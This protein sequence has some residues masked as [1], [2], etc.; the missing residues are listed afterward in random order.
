M[1]HS[2]E[3]PVNLH[4]ISYA[5]RAFAARIPILNSM[6]KQLPGI[7]YKIYTESDIPQD[8]IDKLGPD[9]WGATKGAGYMCWKPWIINDY[10]CQMPDGHNLI[11]IDAGCTSNLVK[12][13]ARRKLNEYLAQVNNPAKCGML[14]YFLPK[15]KECNYTNQYFWDYMAARYSSAS[16]RYPNIATSDYYQTPQIMS[17]VMFMRKCQW[18][19][20]LF[21]EAIQIILD[22][23]E[24][25]SEKHT[26]PGEIHRHDQSLLSLLYKIRGGDLVIPDKTYPRTL[27]TQERHCTPFL[28]TRLRR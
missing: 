24:L 8:F 5:S 3:L 13:P 15:H 23:P 9:V 6:L 17:G 20:E 4:I 7:T 22:N 25:L 16:A 11:Y 28:A 19:S 14:R 21:S 18:V 26:Q 27:T 2:T 12:P 1:S 10:L